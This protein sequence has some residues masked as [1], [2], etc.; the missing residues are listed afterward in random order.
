M[1][2]GVVAKSAA[3]HDGLRRFTITFVGRGGLG[4]PQFN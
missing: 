1:G 3:G 4:A 2:F